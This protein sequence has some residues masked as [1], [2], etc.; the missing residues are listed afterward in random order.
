MFSDHWLRD[1]LGTLVFRSNLDAL[2]IDALAAVA[3]REREEKKIK[4]KSSDGNLPAGYWGGR[5]K[6]V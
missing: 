2:L 6:W 3:E 1:L 4:I 5:C